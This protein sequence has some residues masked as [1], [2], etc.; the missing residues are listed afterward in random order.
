ML[1]KYGII[2]AI[3]N[4]VKIYSI[5]NDS[6]LRDYWC[7]DPPKIVI[8]PV[9]RITPIESETIELSCKVEVEQFASYQWRKDCVQIPNERNHTLVLANVKL[10]DSGNYTCVI[11]NQASST[12]S[13]NAS[14]EVHQFPAFF[15]E[16]DSVDIYLGDSNGAIFQSNATGFPYPHFTLILLIILQ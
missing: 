9:K 3:K 16:P 2:S 4:T 14:V 7:A 11:T 1:Q 6:L 5:A 15:L 13:I 12:I 8:Q 10:S